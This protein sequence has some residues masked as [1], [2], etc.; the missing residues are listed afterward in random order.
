MFQ[1]FKQSPIRTSGAPSSSS[2]GPIARPP[3]DENKGSN[4]HSAGAPVS[5]SRSTV[6]GR[7]RTPDQARATG[8]GRDG[9]SDSDDSI[10]AA[11]PPSTQ[12]TPPVGAK[13]GWM[14]NSPESQTTSLISPTELRSR[15]PMHPPLQF[16]TPQPPQPPPPRQA[17]QTPYGAVRVPP[18]PPSA[19]TTPQPMSS[20]GLPLRFP[21]PS[22]QPTLSFHSE[23]SSSARS[24]AAPNG[25]L[26]GEVGKGGGRAPPQFVRPP[27][28]LP[29]PAFSEIRT[30]FCG[31]RNRRR[32]RVSFGSLRVPPGARVVRFRAP[33]ASS[34]TLQSAAEAAAEPQGEGAASTVE[35][36]RIPDGETRSKRR[37][38]LLLSRLLLLRNGGSGATSLRLGRG[39][40][41][42]CG[43]FLRFSSFLLNLLH[44]VSSF[45][46]IRDPSTD[47]SDLAFLPLPP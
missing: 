12:V 20:Q 16:A 4:P 5:S 32:G 34:R 27:P 2:L 47:D 42:G 23:P 40:G 44:S 45:S 43:G 25:R 36:E 7:E 18:P 31:H 46:L 6:G 35:E 28:S 21:C 22:P 8:D 26:P 15:T 17:P 33:T 38:I 29:P 11:F 19:P 9:A 41:C 39:R 14:V 1:F 37:T 30:P 13:R 24:P 3:R 10:T